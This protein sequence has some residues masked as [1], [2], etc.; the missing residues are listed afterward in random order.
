MTKLDTKEALRIA[1]ANLQAIKIYDEENYTKELHKA[2]CI[3]GHR[4]M[5]LLTVKA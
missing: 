3:L 2:K 1:I 5:D 4:L